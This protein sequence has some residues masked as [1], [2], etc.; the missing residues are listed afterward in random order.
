MANPLV[1]V[2]VPVYNTGEY[3]EKCLK[4]IINQTYHNIEVII[5]DDGSTDE[6]TISLC[7]SFMN[8]YENVKVYRKENGGSADA[9]NYGVS[10]SRGEYVAFVDSDDFIEPDMYLEL[11]RD[12]ENY[13]VKMSICNLVIDNYKVKQIKKPDT[14]KSNGKYKREYILHFYLLGNWHSSCTALYHKSIFDNHKFPVGET[15]EDFIF[16]YQ[17]IKSLEYVSINI[18][19]FY[20]Y[21]KRQNSN[22]TNRASIRNLDWVTHAKLIHEEI[23][24][25]EEFKHLHEESEYQWLFSNIV[26]GN[27]ALLCCS[28]SKCNDDSL[29]IYEEVQNNI[30][31]KSFLILSNRFLPLKYKLSGIMLSLLP[32]VYKFLVTSLV[33]FNRFKMRK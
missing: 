6:S 32:G 28:Y 12:V 20:H 29:E 15:N 25:N 22:T 23:L 10:H 14:L 4:S 33:R 31:N 7:K 8:Q 21:V 19:T 1:S 16:N 5:V 9:R 2:I 17:V 26:L 30:K 3:L 24:N 11:V 18:R 27:K 13:L